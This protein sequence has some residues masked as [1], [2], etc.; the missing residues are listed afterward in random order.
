MAWL[1]SRATGVPK[2]T[3][4]VARQLP[5]ASVRFNSISKVTWGTSK[6]NLANLSSQVT[7]ENG[8]ITWQSGQSSFYYH[9]PKGHYLVILKFLIWLLF[10]I[11]A[12]FFLFYLVIFRLPA[13][14]TVF[15]YFYFFRQQIIRIAARSFEIGAL[16]VPARLARHLS[17]D[18]PTRY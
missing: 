6:V 13:A 9:F 3:S 18:R 17:A 7:C 12:P 5:P 1:E 10:I 15:I 14:W 16:P 11:S 2:D 4:K 8:Q